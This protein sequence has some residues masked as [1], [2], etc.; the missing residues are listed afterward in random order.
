MKRIYVLEVNPPKA[1]TAAKKGTTVMATN[2]LTKFN[3]DVEA[4]KRAHP[5]VKH[6]TAQS[7]VSKTW[8]GSSRPAATKAKSAAK[9]ASR[10]VAKATS[11]KR[12]NQ[13]QVS[14]RP[15]R[16]GAGFGGK[17]ISKVLVKLARNPGDFVDRLKKALSTET[18]GTVV[19]AGAGGVAA[20][21]LPTLIGAHNQGWKGVGLSALATA[22]AA[23]GAALIFP[24]AVIPVA[25]GGV[26]ITFIRGLVVGVPAALGWFMKPLLVW[27]GAAPAGGGA[28]AP[29]GWQVARGQQAGFQKAG[30]GELSGNRIATEEQFGNTPT[31]SF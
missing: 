19:G 1:A 16:K 4:Y 2:A 24:A 20:V 18:A 29:A 22:L 5:T 15:V 23:G 8:S 25:V 6:K 10:A 31:N 27:A 28:G 7:A 17:R 11:K 26:A 9:S 13:K 14:L 12:A 3:S 30:G 21:F